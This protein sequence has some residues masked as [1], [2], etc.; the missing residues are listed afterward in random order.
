VDPLIRRAST[1]DAAALARHMSDPAVFG[2]LLQLPYPS[3]EAWQKRLAEGALANTADVLLVAERDTAVLGAAGLLAPS[4]Q[5][6]RRHVMALGISV[7]PAAQRQGIG[8]ALMAALCDYADRWAGVLRIELTVYTDNEVAQR[9]YRRFGFEVE[10]TLRAYALRDGA[11]VD[12]L[13]MARLHP[14]PPRPAAAR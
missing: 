4:P 6:R 7:A 11:Y 13:S 5:V 8:S 9:L 2:G 1:R 10:G 3:E 14:N 12:A